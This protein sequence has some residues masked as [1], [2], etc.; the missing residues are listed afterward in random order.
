MPDASISTLETREQFPRPNDVRPDSFVLA[1]IHVDAD[2]WRLPVQL[3]SF[4]QLLLP[5]TLTNRL[6][7]VPGRD[8]RSTSRRRRL[9]V[10]GYA[11]LGTPLDPL[12]RRENMQE[13]MP[14]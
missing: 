7:E 1:D 9:S 11:G 13:Y 8:K 10:P 2:H 14:I 4:R 3:H 6:E 5:T 12:I